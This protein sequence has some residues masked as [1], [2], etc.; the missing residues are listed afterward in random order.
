MTDPV[1]VDYSDGVVT[2]VINRPEA[3]NA[4]N[5]AV[6]EAIASAITTLEE[7]DDLSVGVISGAGGTFCA[8]MDLKAYVA[9]ENVLVNGR[10]LAGMC[11]VPPTKPVI[12]AI[13]GWA[14]AGGCEIALACDMIVASNDAKFGIPEVKRGLVAGAGGLIR[15]PQRI[16]RNVANEL[17]LTGDPISAARAYE[18]GLVNQITEPG[19]ALSAAT[20]LA[21][22]LTPNGPLAMAATKAVLSRSS[23]WSTETA[24]EQQNLI[25][26]PVFES[27]DAR[28]GAVAFAEKRPPVWK[29]R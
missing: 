12:A 6:A 4:V 27:E 17:A 16:P 22:R 1:L 20:E 3:K 23:D 29:N 11:E 26:N 13:E 21:R 2:I 10:G 25:V 9:G 18:L 19:S 28:E 5:Q 7:R 24:F 14:L 8:G 15:L